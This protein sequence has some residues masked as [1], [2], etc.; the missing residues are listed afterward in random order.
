MKPKM[1]IK[2][3]NQELEEF[4]AREKN[5]EPRAKA[6]LKVAK[7]S[8]PIGTKVYYTKSEL[9]GRVIL[10]TAS[11][12]YVLGDDHPVVDLE[13]IGMVLLEKVDLAS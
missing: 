8:H 9:E 10:K 12:A 3:T 4:S 13:F 7:W 2:A 1:I 5:G 11:E 6:L